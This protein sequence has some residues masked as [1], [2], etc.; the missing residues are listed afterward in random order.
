MTDFL[1]DD[2]VKYSNQPIKYHTVSLRVFA[3]EEKGVSDRR[4]KYDHDVTNCG[5]SPWQVDPS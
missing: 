5:L 1:F 3:E 2:H 4:M